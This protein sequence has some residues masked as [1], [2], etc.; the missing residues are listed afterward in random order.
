MYEYIANIG[1]EKLKKQL[2]EYCLDYNLNNL[3][4]ELQFIIDIQ[5]RICAYLFIF[6]ID[7]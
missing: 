1:L 5:K 6:F 7:T 4:L 2:L 3:N